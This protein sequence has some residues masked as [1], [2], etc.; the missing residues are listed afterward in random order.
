MI[1][2]TLATDMR[3]EIS[4]LEK[5]DRAM[6]AIREVVEMPGVRASL[7]VRLILQN[8]GRLSRAKRGQFPEL[9]DNE[10]T[11][12]EAALAESRKEGDR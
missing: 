10:I 7:L 9:T 11:A 1:S 6:E 12:I 4:F 8:H 3:T 5:Y 2:D